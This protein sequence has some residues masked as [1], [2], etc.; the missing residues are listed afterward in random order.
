[1]Q[2]PNIASEYKITKDDVSGNT[3]LPDSIRVLPNLTRVRVNLV[4]GGAFTVQGYG[5]PFANPGHASDDWINCNAPIIGGM[6]LLSI[7]RSQSLTF[8]VAKP[9]PVVH[10]GKVAMPP[11]SVYPYNVCTVHIFLRAAVTDA[12]ECSTHSS[13]RSPSLCPHSQT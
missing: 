6:D 11:P 1:M 10:L 13:Q 4:E 12:S 3:D 2:L 7:L 5:I 8:L 9:Q